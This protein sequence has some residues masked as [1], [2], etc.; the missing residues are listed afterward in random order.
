MH[1][2]KVLAQLVYKLS[3]KDEEANA[4]V[5]RLRKLPKLSEGPPF[6][7]ADK[8]WLRERGME[9]IFLSVCNTGS[10]GINP[11]QIIVYHE[12]LYIK[13]LPEQIRHII[14]VSTILF[15][16]CQPWTGGM[17]RGRCPSPARYS[18]PTQT[19][20][21]GRHPGSSSALSVSCLNFCQ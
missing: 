12:H 18:S 16:F 19:S 5:C 15:Y 7:L 4:M 20:S 10:T 21:S 8:R 9:G 6:I 17:R 2:L 14:K 3:Q 13:K 1:S 11:V